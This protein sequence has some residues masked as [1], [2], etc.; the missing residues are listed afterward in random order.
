[1]VNDAINY[2]TARGI[3]GL[4]FLFC[5]HGMAVSLLKQKVCFFVIFIYEEDT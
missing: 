3:I 2:T 1:M 4:K 5:I